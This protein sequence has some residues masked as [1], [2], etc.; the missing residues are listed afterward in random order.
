MPLRV[1]LGLHIIL[2]E[3]CIFV[4]GGGG[5]NLQ[6]KM[7]CK[8]SPNR[9]GQGKQGSLTESFYK[10]NNNEEKHRES[11]VFLYL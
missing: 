11:D 6:L 10:T 3:E 4:K 5:V 2:R 7:G 9:K 1:R 8:K